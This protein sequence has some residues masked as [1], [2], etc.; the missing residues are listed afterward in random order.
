MFVVYIT[1]ISTRLLFF[2]FA[3]SFPLLFVFGYST[4]CDSKSF[5]SVMNTAALKVTLKSP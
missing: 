1:D 4:R 2:S 3:R 5:R